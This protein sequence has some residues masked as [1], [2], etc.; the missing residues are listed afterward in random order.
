MRFANDREEPRERGR[1]T[2]KS[3][4]NNT[5]VSSF[6]CAIIPVVENNSSLN[7]HF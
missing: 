5:Y 7:L 1:G 6:I 4:V 2:N 3:V